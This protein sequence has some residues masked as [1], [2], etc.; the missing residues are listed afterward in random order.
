MHCLCF[1]CTLTLY[2]SLIPLIGLC[3]TTLPFSVFLSLFLSIYFYPSSAVR[4]ITLCLTYTCMFCDANCQFRI[5]HF[6]YYCYDHYLDWPSDMVRFFTWSFSIYTMMSSYPHAHSHARTHTRTNSLCDSNACMQI[7]N[8]AFKGSHDLF[9]RM[10]FEC[11]CCVRMLCMRVRLLL[12][13]KL[14]FVYFISFQ[15]EISL[16]NAS[17]CVCVPT[18]ELLYSRA[19]G[20]F[21]FFSFWRRYLF[22]ITL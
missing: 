20:F 1:Y 6:C 14:S 21:L 3:L 2:P 10:C 4:R 16:Q 9:I 7:A 19:C 15:T 18:F 13:A 8:S 5:F 12:P 11:V 22:P 17:M